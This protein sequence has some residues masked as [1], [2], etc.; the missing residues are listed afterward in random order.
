MLL[1]WTFAAAWA[2]TVKLQSPAPLTYRVD[3][4]VT[5]RLTTEAVLQLADG[6][7]RLEALDAFGRVVASTDIIL[8]PGEPLWFA[9]EN[10]RFVQREV[11]SRAV[12]DRPPI[13]DVQYQW[14][15]HRII[16][17]RNEEKK[18]KRLAE[19]VNRSWF[20]MRHVD[21][22]LAAFPSLEGRVQAARM[23]APRTI[24]PEKTRAIESHFP[25]GDFRDRALGAFAFYQRDVPEDDE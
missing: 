22:L 18:L 25:P 13:S 7:H 8:R 24:D 9:C 16:R 3:G 14:L 11:S 10:H 15:E 5:S 21:K 23:L 12:G 20:E 4:E 2:G 19:V 17:K 1:M 6:G